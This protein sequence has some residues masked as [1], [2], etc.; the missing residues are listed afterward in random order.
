MLVAEHAHLHRRTAGCPPEP[1]PGEEPTGCAADAFAE[2][3]RCGHSA[4]C[5]SGGGIRSA[6]FALGVM[7]G[8]ARHGLLRGF[9]Y[10]STVSGGG[11]A[12]GWLS[13]WLFH[14]GGDGDAVFAALGRVRSGTSVEPEPVARMRAAGRYMSPEMGTFTAD[15]WTLIATVVRNQFLNSLVLLPLLAAALLLPHLYLALIQQFYRPVQVTA[16]ITLDPATLMLL[17]SGGLT[18]LSFGFIVRQLP[19]YGNA[20]GD[21]Q[22]FLLWSLL[23][24]VLGAI[25]LTLF[26][27]AE[28]F[29]IE[30]GPTALI[31]ALVGGTTWTAVGLFGGARRWRPRSSAGATAAGT[32][33]ASAF[34]ALGRLFAG[35]AT[36]GRLFAMTAVPLVLGSLTVA[37]FVFLGLA[38]A[39]MGDEDLEWWGRVGSCVLIVGAGWLALAGLVYYGPDA[40]RV[41]RGYVEQDVPGMRSPGRAAGAIGL[42]TSALGGISAYLA[43]ALT[44]E[45]PGESRPVKRI[46]VALA[47]PAFAVLLAASLAW[48]NEGLLAAIFARTTLTTADL[49]TCGANYLIPVLLLGGAFLGFGLVAGHF[50]PV[51]QFSLHGMYRE[52][53]IRAFLG[54]SRPSDA[55]RP[56][57][58]TGFDSD[59][60]IPLSELAAIERPALVVNMTLNCVADAALGRLHRKAES[61][62]ASPLFV[63][64]ASL[65]Y[66]PT[67]EYASN[68]RLGRR[69]MSLGTAMTISGAAASPNMGARSS[70]SLT[71]LLTLCNARLGAWLGNPGIFGSD[72]WR[73]SE[74]RQGVAPLL[75]EL[76]GRTSAVSPHVYLSDGGHCEN[77][78]LYQ[79]LLRRCRYI[80]V[81]DAGCDEDYAFEDL[82]VAIRQARIDLG[83]RVVFAQGIPMDR[84]HQGRG[85]PHFAIGRILYT[86]VDGPAATDGILIYVKATL[87][88]DEPLDVLNYARAH[89]AFPH[90]STA[91]QWFDEAQF[92]SYRMLGDHSIEQIVGRYDGGNELWE[93]F[94]STATQ[95]AAPTPP[96]KHAAQHPE[97]T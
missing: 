29:P 13:G 42:F 24:L 92:E 12:G 67:A 75:R 16:T 61:F 17:V 81:S 19:S 39:E 63:G 43:R 37:T 49:D 23:P 38:S 5:L 45:K 58:F 51:N 74:P 88:G 91:D 82:A 53:L 77:L 8:L 96:P 54:A 76:L 68:G 86:A 14:A 62:T 30:R 57:P 85:N 73:H 94:H 25:G 66:R 83:I 40:L 84:Q 22:T 36:C 44:A 95:E 70:P 55:R 97:P 87:S 10:L 71:L 46:A 79:M 69:G 3:H 89:P 18:A 21:Q 33:A 27:T 26:W 90:E 2:R 56:N 20:R 65:G 32:I 60:D 15:M 72:T 50:V 48:M 52:R 93:F 11:F 31:G 34:Y 1:V 47:A 78:G 7:E 28:D 35:E 9:D 6:S 64:S 4:L 80:L 59:D 41:V